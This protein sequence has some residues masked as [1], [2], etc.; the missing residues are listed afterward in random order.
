MILGFNHDL[1]PIIMSGWVDSKNVSSSAPLAIMEL[2]FITAILILWTCGFSDLG[3][4]LEEEAASCESRL[5][6]VY[7]LDSRLVFAWG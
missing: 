2:Q 6:V 5:V 7:G 4:A 1:V 3:G